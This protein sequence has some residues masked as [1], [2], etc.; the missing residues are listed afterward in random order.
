MDGDGLTS[1]IA[2]VMI[3][4]PRPA[5]RSRSRITSGDTFDADD[6]TNTSARPD[7]SAA[8]TSSGGP[9]D[10]PEKQVIALAV[11][12]SASSAASAAFSRAA[13]RYTSTA[14]VI[15]SWSDPIAGVGIP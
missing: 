11:N 3:G 6:R 10:A 15:R 13:E 1:S 5:A 12:A 14:A 7:S 2:Y 9:A 4:I 8:N